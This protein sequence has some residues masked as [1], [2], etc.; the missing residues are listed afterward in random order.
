MKNL[1]RN[2]FI[3]IIFSGAY[4]VLERYAMVHTAFIYIPFSYAHPVVNFA[5]LIY[6][7]LFGAIS[8]A[9]GEFLSMLGNELYDWPAVFCAF[10]N[11]GSIGFAMRNNKI[12]EGLFPRREQLRFDLTQFLSNLFCWAGLYPVLSSLLLQKNFQSMFTIGLGKAIG[13][14]ITNAI[15]GTLLLSLYAKTRISAANFYRS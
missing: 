4:Y 9:L 3:I 5:G 13:M 7:P 2:I 11:C 8:C 15:A 6:G 14:S 1:L 10:L 12:R